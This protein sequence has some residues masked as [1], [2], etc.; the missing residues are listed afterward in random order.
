MEI[1][2]KALKILTILLVGILM[3]A[4]AWP[5]ISQTIDGINYSRENFCG[6]LTVLSTTLQ[7]DP[8]KGTYI[9][10]A[11]I[12]REDSTVA[13][14]YITDWTRRRLEIEGGGTSDCITHASS[15][16]FKGAEFLLL[17]NDTTPGRMFEVSSHFNTCTNNDKTCVE[18]IKTSLSPEL[19]KLYEEPI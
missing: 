5:L 17:S 8:E 12:K 1:I 13:T 6:K 18:Q 14:I 2:V 9:Y 3:L 19:Q 11:S 16:G 7:S 10:E 4:L 15:L